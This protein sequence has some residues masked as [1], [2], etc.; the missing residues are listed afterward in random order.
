M[1]RPDEVKRQAILHAARSHFA[2]RPFHEV[3]LEDL[4]AAARVG[5][6]T[7]YVYFE[8]KERLYLEVLTQG[9]DELVEQ[10]AAIGRV[11]GDAWETLRSIVTHLAGWSLENR[12]LFELMRAGVHPAG[13]AA[14]RRKRRTLGEVIERVIER[15]VAD[16][17]LVDPAPRLTAQFIPA[18]IRSAVVWGPRGVTPDVLAGQVL[19]MLAVLR[20]E[21][22]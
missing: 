18:M 17:S 1:Q 15:G 13:T 4:A 9:F 7:L 3:R 11:P 19:R 8:S 14:I 22:A 10:L 21:R 20:K 6:G 5:K 16:A 12:A 2:R